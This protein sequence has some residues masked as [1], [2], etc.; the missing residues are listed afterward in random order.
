MSNN[1]KLG[2]AREIITPEVGSCLYGYRPDVHSTCVNDDL[3]ATAFYF[4]DGTT[5]ALM[6]SATVCSINTKLCCDLRQM[7]EEKFGIPYGNIIISATHTHSGPNLAGTVGWG[8]VDTD[9]RDGIF[10]PKMLEAVRRA[11]ESAVPAKMGMAY[12]DSLAGIN[13]RQ[14]NINN[15]I[16]LGQNPWGPFNPRMCIISFKNEAGNVIANIIHY[17]AHGTASGCNTEISRDWH[18]VMI[19][20]VE[21]LSGGITA[22]F[23]GPEGDVGPRML[24]GGT[25]GKQ[26]VKYALEH[27]AFAAQDAVRIFRE[28]KAYRDVQLKAVCENLTIPLKN[29]MPRE[30]AEALYEKFKEQ[31]VNISGQHKN[32]AK[33]VLDS[34]DEGYVD[35]ESFDIKQTIIRLSDVAF[36]AF[37]YELFSEIGMRI[38]RASSVPYVLSLAESNGCDGYFVTQ[39]ALC[40]GGYE[41]D[42]FKTARVQPYRDDADFALVTGTLENLNKAEL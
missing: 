28:V 36:A 11:K 2:I 32:Y 4:T 29:R 38:D 22:F 37:P 13:R 6:I 20:A 9:Y 24:N 40:R 16:G 3:T 1:F 10:I 19:D 14:L 15:H 42:M 35:T 26:S 30:E 23:N 27:G 33:R 39:D 8:D 12:G 17:G 21:Q 41:V 5:E 31:T 34:Y 25:T 7:F 18:G